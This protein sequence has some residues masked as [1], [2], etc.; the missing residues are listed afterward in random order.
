[1]TI[2]VERHYHMW[3]QYLE[4][5]AGPLLILH[6]VL[7]GVHHEGHL[8]FVDVLSG[9]WDIVRFGCFC[10]LHIFLEGVPLKILHVEAICTVVVHHLL[11]L[12]LEQTKA[13]D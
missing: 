6:S 11:V 13:A 4:G 12:G 7:G 1:M 8:N 2:H 10:N 9:D 5:P 3:K